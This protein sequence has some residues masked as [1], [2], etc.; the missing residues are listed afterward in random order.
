M[1]YALALAGRH[2]ARLL[3]DPSLVYGFLLHDIGKIGVPD[4]ILLKRGPLTP[5]ERRIMRR[6][7]VL[8]EEILGDV[9]LLDGEG[10]KIVRSHHERW[11]G[12]GYPDALGAEAIPVGARIFSVADALDAMTTERPYR[13]PASWPAAVHEIEREAGR[14]FDPDVVETFARAEPE[15]RGIFDELNSVAA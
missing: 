6:H 10:L 8:G 3:S 5:I 13:R 14:H 2:D 1:R 11:D 9:A 4:R 7:P 15:L 12:G